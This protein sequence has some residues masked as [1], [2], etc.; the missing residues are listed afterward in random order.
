MLKIFY[1]SLD[2]A[3]MNKRTGINFIRFGGGGPARPGLM[4]QKDASEGGSLA[5][6]QYFL[7][8]PFTERKGVI[9]CSKH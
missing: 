6:R 3:G 1:F 2:R 7:P 4:L 5:P 8:I 9:L